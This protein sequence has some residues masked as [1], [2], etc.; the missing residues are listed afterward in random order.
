SLKP[1]NIH[2]R[3]IKEKTDDLSKWPVYQIKTDA[4][5][6]SVKSVGISDED[7]IRDLKDLILPEYNFIPI[8]ATLSVLALI[9]LGVWLFKKYKNFLSGTNAKQLETVDYYVEALKQ[10]DDLESQD[11]INQEMFNRFHTS[12][13]DI[14]RNYIEYHFGLHA[15]EQTTQ[16]FI[17]HISNAKHFTLDQQAILDRFLSLADLVKFA[18]FDPGSKTSEDAM[19]N[20]RN[21]II[22]TGI[23]DGI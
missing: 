6:Y 3:L 23:S 14:L 4:I 10:L 17:R 11:L 1:F 9:V 15:K 20:V 5:D 21:F 13:S 2:F 22:T 8:A 16:E 18:T 19:K 12:L 7:D